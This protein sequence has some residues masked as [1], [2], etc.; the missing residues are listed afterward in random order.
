MWI[1]FLIVRCINKETCLLRGMNPYTNANWNVIIQL[2][3]KLIK[4]IKPAWIHLF[5][6]TYSEKY[7]W[8]S[9]KM[10]NLILFFFT[11]WIT[12]HF[13][14]AKFLND[15]LNY[16]QIV[17]LYYHIILSFYV[18]MLYHITRFCKI[19]VL[20]IR[21]RVYVMFI[22]RFKIHNQHHTMF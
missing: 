17:I 1:I 8:L 4:L 15:S 5:D 10:F 3:M 18:E 11:D 13:T 6:W 2:K 16:F 9:V 12:L 14:E 20:Y 21:V 7:K 19:S 22:L